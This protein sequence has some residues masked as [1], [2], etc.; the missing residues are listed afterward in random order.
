MKVPLYKQV[1]LL[2]D[3]PEQGLM[4]GDVAT[5]VDFLESPEAGVPNGYFVEAS[6]ALGK[7]IAVFIVYEDDIEALAEHDVLHKRVLVSTTDNSDSVTTW[8]GSAIR[9]T[10]SG[11]FGLGQ[12]REDQEWKPF[13]AANTLSDAAIVREPVNDPLDKLIIEQGLRIKKLFFDTELDL[14]IVLLT[15]GRVLSLKLSGFA[16]LKNATAEQL[17]T[18]ELED[19]GTAVRWESLNED[20]SV[21]GFI[22]QAAME[23]T[24]YH[25]AKVV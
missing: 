10:Q 7:T 16:R 19:D 17:A 24:L 25:L 4:I 23:E 18:Y 22:K 13:V 6:N 2:K 9:E 3:Y 12:R 20:L 1:A 8:Q 14:I 21:R 5:T 15:N 11:F